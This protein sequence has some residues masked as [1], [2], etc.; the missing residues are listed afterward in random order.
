VGLFNHRFPDL[1]RPI[2]V[3]NADKVR[4]RC[5]EVARDLAGFLGRI[6]RNRAG[7]GGVALR[8]VEIG[9]GPANTDHAV[10]QTRPRKNSVV[11][12]VALGDAFVVAPAV[13]KAGG[14]APIQISLTIGP[15]PV[16]LA[17]QEAGENIF[18]GKID[19][20][21]AGRY[22]NASRRAYRGDAI[23]LDND[24]RVLHWRTAEAINKRPA[25]KNHRGLP[26][27]GQ[28]QRCTS[29][30]QAQNNSKRPIDGLRVHSFLPQKKAS[31]SPYRTSVRRISNGQKN[32]PCH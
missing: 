9:T 19:T 27:R 22:I 18:S 25:F 26:L 7:A 4:A 11:H 5:D 3:A 30:E 23:A 24:Y 32:T 15:V 29:H 28:R 6:G 31:A 1:E 2:A 12:R 17:I 16:G 8:P 20:L 21:G 14:H 10:I 13:H